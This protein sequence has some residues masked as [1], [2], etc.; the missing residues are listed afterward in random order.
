MISG[1]GAAKPIVLTFVNYYLP[2]YKAGG[3][4]RTI[5]NMVEAMGDDLDFRVVTSD[6]D[7]T[8][9][10]AYSVL[11]G[12]SGWQD[13]GKAK[14]L[15]LSPDQKYFANIVKI[16]RQTQHDTVYLNSLFD[17]HF[18]LKPLL[19][20]RLGLMPKSRYVIAP[21]G[22]LSTGA[23][24]LKALK[25][26]AFLSASHLSGFYRDLIWQA[27]SERELQDIRMTMGAIAP[28]IR[29]ASDLPAIASR[30]VSSVSRSRPKGEPLRV[31]FLSRISP[32]KNL[33]YALEVLHQVKLPVRFD[34]YGPVRDEAYWSRCQ[35]IM[36]S[37]PDHVVATYC[38]SVE[39]DRVSSI[40][41]EYDLFFLPTLGENYGHAIVEAL[42]VG[43][44]VLIADTTPWRDL[45]AIGVGWELSLAKP[46]VFVEKIQH[47]GTLSPPEQTRMRTQAMLFAERQR[48]D[49][50]VVKANKQLFLEMPTH[51]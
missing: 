34:I 29:I 7:A 48:M 21:R 12:R 30:Q 38:G 19:G 1:S 14:V 23:L 39:H 51:S 20:R 16:I 2:G 24:E 27:S 47:M 44:P 45:A 4:L 41:A 9:T 26:K 46:E 50:D 32:M 33:D 6:R 15:Y 31:G 49:S 25:K 11:E 28:D 10:A 8:D 42:A 5:S 35:E 13:V 36:S 17:S 43:T 40:L 3:P 37:L 22:E 18:T